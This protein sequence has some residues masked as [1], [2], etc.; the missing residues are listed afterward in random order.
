MDDS[1]CVLPET[2]AGLKAGGVVVVN[3][4]HPLEKLNVPEQAGIVIACDAT[5]ISEA[6][7]G[8]NLPN[9]AV[10]GAMSHILKFIDR[11]LLFSEIEKTFNSLNRKAAETAF[12]SIRVLKGEVSE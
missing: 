4:V 3:T 8:T 6:L 5:G 10:L 9:T 1:L 12:D 11:E 7:F 2:Y